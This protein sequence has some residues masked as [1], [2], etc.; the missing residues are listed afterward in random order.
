[1]SRLPP[2][3]RTGNVGDAL[4]GMTSTIQTPPANDER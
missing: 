3:V 1:M 4:D 2:I